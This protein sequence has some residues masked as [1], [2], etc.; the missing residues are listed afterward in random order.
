[1]AHAFR[2]G[3][4]VLFFEESEETG[5]RK[6]LVRAGDKVDRYRGLGVF[7]PGKLVGLAPG[8]R[9]KVGTRDFTLIRP[10]TGDLLSTLERKAQI[11]L[12]KEAGPILLHAGIVPGA[13]VVEAGIGSGA[14]TTALAAAVGEKGRVVTYELREDFAEHA[15]G[16]LARAGLADRVEIRIGDVRTGIEQRDVD[17]VILDMPDPWAALDAAR[18]ALAIGG[19]IAIYSPLVS[20][21]E[22]TV[23]ALRERKFGDVRVIEILE[24]EWVVGERGSRPS[25]DMLGHSGFLVFARKVSPHPPPEPPPKP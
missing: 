16:N 23:R 4:P 5:V 9:F 7:D 6:H 19:A 3:D 1:M 25:F 24:R 22:Q 13:T 12:A 8:D 14:L 18:E 2:S 15:R 17:A 21:V 10:T 20:Q 11:V